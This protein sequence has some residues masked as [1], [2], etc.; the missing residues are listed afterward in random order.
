[1]PQPTRFDA[2]DYFDSE[3]RQVAHFAAALEI[4]DTDYSLRPPCRR[5]ARPNG[6]AW[7]D[8]CDGRFQTLI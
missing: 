8:G 7:H 1:M 3:E 2:A 5:G 4:G 6:D